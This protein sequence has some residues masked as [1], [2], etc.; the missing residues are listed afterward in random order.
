MLESQFVGFQKRL[1]RR[2]W[3]RPMER[4]T[5]G[6]AAHRKHLQRLTLTSQVGVGFV[7]ID[8]SLVA[9]GV[10]LWHTRLRSNS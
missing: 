3:V 1:L 10:L 4:G 9:P 7:P 6:H 5:A 8:L 2:A